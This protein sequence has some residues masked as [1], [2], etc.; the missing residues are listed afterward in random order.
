MFVT[1]DCFKNKPEDTIIYLITCNPSLPQPNGVDHVLVC[2]EDA[3]FAG[4]NLSIDMAL[5][6][7]LQYYRPLMLSQEQHPNQNK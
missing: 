2:N 5:G 1:P 6:L 4:G 3:G 7:L